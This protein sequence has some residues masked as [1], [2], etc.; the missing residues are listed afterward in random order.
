MFPRG[1]LDTNSQ[2]E[3]SQGCA[4]LF[5]VNKPI[6]WPS[7]LVTG[8]VSAGNTVTQG[9]GVDIAA[10]VNNVFAAAENVTRTRRNFEIATIGRSSGMNW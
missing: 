5:G 1:W 2:H 3:G 6:S 7:S 9:T 4:A 8:A 10:D